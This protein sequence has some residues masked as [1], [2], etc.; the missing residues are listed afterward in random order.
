MALTSFG[1]TLL[2]AFLNYH[3]GFML[4][5]IKMMNAALSSNELEDWE[6]GKSRVYHC[7]IWSCFLLHIAQRLLV[8][9]TTCFYQQLCNK[10]I[11]DKK[12][13]SLM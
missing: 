4:M 6:R 9:L 13:V 11:I 5:L 10:T 3:I 1:L 2:S 7:M 8:I 12:H